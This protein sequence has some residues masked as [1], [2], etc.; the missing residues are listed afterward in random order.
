MAHFAKIEDGIVVDVIV[1]EQEFID[2]GAVGD[3]S[4]W[5]QTSYNT[6]GGIHYGADGNPDGGVALRKNYAGIGF[7]Y[8]SEKDAF[9]PQKMFDS[10][11]L[12]EETCL[13]EAPIPYPEN[14]EGV[15]YLWNESLYQ[16]D[17]TQ[18]WVN[19]LSIPDPNPQ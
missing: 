18:G 9:I 12:N 14:D 17:N 7:S 4:M 15:I 6:R 13:W 11:V 19:S 5:V 10:W 16:S 3:P 2:S 1:A 8:D